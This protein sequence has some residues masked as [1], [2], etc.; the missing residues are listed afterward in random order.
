MLVHNNEMRNAKITINLEI[1]I[2][3]LFKHRNSKINFINDFLKRKIS[4]NV[5]QD[6]L[7]NCG[8]IHP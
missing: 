3:L 2:F 8:K 4:E 7:E 1:I 6:L 5:A